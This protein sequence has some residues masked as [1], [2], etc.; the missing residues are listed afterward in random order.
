[1]SINDMPNIV[2]CVDAELLVFFIGKLLD[3]LV[4]VDAYK[5]K[6]ETTIR[7]YVIAALHF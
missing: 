5:L 2:V 6:G 3:Q 7:K 1:M 4:G